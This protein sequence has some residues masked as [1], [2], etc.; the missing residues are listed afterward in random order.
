MKKIISLNNVTVRFNLASERIDSIKE[1]VLKLVKGTLHFQEFLALK[2]INLE[3]NEGESWA[4]IGSNGAGKSTLLKVITGILTPYN[5]AI[6]VKGN[7]SSIIELAAGFDPE[8]TARENV[9]LNGAFL[10]MDKKTIDDNFDEIIK[11]AELEEF[12]D[13]PVKNFSS[14]M[15]A[16]LGFS[17]ATII[18]PEIL[19]IDEVL[20]VGDINFQRKSKQRMLDLI[21]GDVTLIYVSHDLNS[22]R[23]LCDK[24]LWIEKGEMIMSGEVNEVCDAYI[25]RQEGK[26]E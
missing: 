18:K 17:I 6:E 16:R 12:V 19:I 15:V 3:I 14:G 2:N 21:N 1:Y 8:M 24:A 10:G 5:G 7:V 13:S 22:V 9:Y 4:L 11:F 23:E 25:R 20:S 26:Y